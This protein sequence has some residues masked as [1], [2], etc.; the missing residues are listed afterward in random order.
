MRKQ[1]DPPGGTNRIIQGGKGGYVASGNVDISR[2]RDI[3]TVHNFYVYTKYSTP[4]RIL[5][6]TSIVYTSII[7]H[8]QVFYYS[9]I[10]DFDPTATESRIKRSRIQHERRTMTD[11][12]LNDTTSAI[13]STTNGS[14]HALPWALPCASHTTHGRRLTGQRVQK[15]QPIH[16][17][18][19]V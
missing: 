14:L 1:L 7:Y 6:S 13:I 17:Q 19:V 15:R 18:T 4:L 2:S 8:D 12:K 9:S 3:R 16:L 10:L 5:S 11:R